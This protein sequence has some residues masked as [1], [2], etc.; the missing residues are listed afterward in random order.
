MQMGDGNTIITK[1]TNIKIQKLL[2][3]V[4]ITFHIFCIFSSSLRYL[5]VSP[6]SERLLCC[7]YF[8]LCIYSHIWEKYKTPL[9]IDHVHFSFSIFFYCSRICKI[10]H[11]PKRE[12]LEG[13]FKEEKKKQEIWTIIPIHQKDTKIDLPF[14]N[15]SP[16]FF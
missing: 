5:L 13:A 1:V 14:W 15:T 11:P 8:M 2:I 16:I 4:K 10:N 3:L 6:P 12:F 7:P 9:H